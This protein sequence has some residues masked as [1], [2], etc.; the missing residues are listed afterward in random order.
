MRPLHLR[1]LLLSS[2]LFALSGRSPGQQA[3]FPEP[4]SPRIANYDITVTLDADK[5]TLQ[6]SETLIWHNPSPDA[7]RE[8]RF[9]LYLNAFKN[10]QSTFM[11]ESRGY[12]R[13][14]SATEGGWG[15]IAVNSM[16]TSDDIDLT[17]SMEFVAPDDGNERDQTVLRVA[18]PDPVPP[19][20]TIQLALQFTARLPK[21]FARTGYAKDFFMVGQWFPKIGV[22][23]W[24]GQRYATTGQWNCHQFHSN[25]EFF[26]DFG[27]YDVTIT[28]P[29]QYI[30]GATG[31]QVAKRRNSNGTATVTY[32]AEDVHDFA[33]TASP[34][35]AD[36]RDE[37]HHVSLRALM[38]PQRVHQASRYFGAVKAAL[39]HLTA[40]VGPYPYPNITIVDPAFGAEGAG[41]MEYPT[42]IT[43]GSMAGVGE[44][45]RMAEM[46]AAHEFGHQYWYG[47]VASNEFED[48]WLDEGVNQYYEGRI[49]TEEYGLK[50]SFL[51]LAGI[52]IGDLEFTRVGYLSMRNPKLAPITTFGWKFP[53]GGYGSLT[54]MKTAAALTTLE[55]I[56]GRATMDSVMKTYFRRW[57][58]KH[59]CA[60]DFVQTFNEI[61][62]AIRG[63]RFGKDLN[64]FFDQLLFGTDLCDYEVTSISNSTPPPPH[65][66]I[67]SSWV[68]KTGVGTEELE[69][70]V[71][72]SRLG[73][74][75]L[76]VDLLVHFESG[77]E[78]VDTWNG[79]ERVKEFTYH[80]PS[81]VVW[82]VVDPKEKLVVDAC[83]VNN[84][85]A[86]DPP[87]SPVRKYTAKVLFWIQNILQLFAIAG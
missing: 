50:T 62:P 33:W 16:K 32:H 6:G 53:P 55:N 87:A 19:N 60:R 41:G 61:V 64:W 22:Y 37:W 21:V 1:F 48:A 11:K 30:V 43:A 3:I 26:S 58:F 56:I 72:V 45:V 65:G 42:L 2:F 75:R 57:R 15:W 71:T 68:K 24:A 84:S 35:F 49:M 59:P 69:S 25:T 74:V 36:L 78:I 29:E 85:K 14:L 4:L 82:A 40:H 28:T 77:E 46:V 18:L 12:S 31:L 47:M 34:H 5:K 54:Y 70:T 80:K 13:G 20:G 9:H 79:Q 17:T 86:I 76:P 7:I 39:E 23:E 38:Q 63:D 83:I 10:N 81:R 66:E 44:S 52:G 51:N 27:V 8:L 67:D 73:E